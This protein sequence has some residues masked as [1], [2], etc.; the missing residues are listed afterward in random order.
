V[1]GRGSWDELVQL[2][3]IAI[4]QR[5]RLFDFYNDYIRSLVRSEGTGKIK[6]ELYV[7]MDEMKVFLLECHRLAKEGLTDNLSFLIGKLDD[8]AYKAS[9]CIAR[10]KQAEDLTP[11][12]S[13]VRILHEILAVGL[14]VSRNKLVPDV[15]KSRLPGLQSYIMY[16]QG[17]IRQ[18]R[19]RYPDQKVLLQ[20]FQ[21]QLSC[22][23]EGAG[24]LF[25]YMQNQNV[26]SLV[27]ALSL[28]DRAGLG[29]WAAYSA[30]NQLFVEEQSFSPDPLVDDVHRVIQA[31]K[32]GTAKEDKMKAAFFALTEQHKMSTIN[33]VF[34][35]NFYFIRPPVKEQYIPPIVDIL[36]RKDAILAY[37]SANLASPIELEKSLAQYEGLC[38]WQAE[39]Q[40]ELEKAIAEK[41]DLSGAA[42][43]E[44]LLGL[45]EKVY[46]EKMPDSRLEQ[47]A[48]FMD[49]FGGD[50]RRNLILQER[51]HPETADIVADMYQVLDDHHEGLNIIFEYLEIGDRGLLL[52]AY[53]IIESSTLRML[54]LRK[55]GEEKAAQ[56]ESGTASVACPFCGA[57]NGQGAYQCGRCGRP[58]LGQS[59]LGGG[60]LDVTE[61]D[62]MPEGAASSEHLTENFLFIKQ[63]VED[64]AAGLLSYQEA[65]QMLLPY[66]DK[67]QEIEDNLLSTV[68]PTVNESGDEELG[69]CYDEFYEILNY[70]SEVMKEI[71]VGIQRRN[72][73]ILTKNIRSI[74][75]AGCDM[76]R[77][78]MDLQKSMAKDREM[79]YRPQ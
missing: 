63:V 33:L 70:F 43:F 73:D 66:W 36:A 48:V 20:Y 26:D 68:E 1:A 10:L 23:K 11:R 13:S 45:I 56:A 64:T 78:H 41:P 59:S 47:K 39:K 37:M 8:S 76:K 75:E 55:Q 57:L 30:M 28:L 51:R 19:E 62:G 22:L 4:T 25:L 32:K 5:D 27:V 79:E 54:E 17:T 52:Q 40:D 2:L 12:L 67:I 15:L 74:I 50:F 7:A 3:E 65:E 21:Q 44:E 24:G 49:E 35:E 31:Y 16:V 58:V 18:L 29:L 14:D 34:L 6:A 61:S 46:E 71:F 38:R 60:V 53:D 69:R 77:L 9:S 42:H 72:P